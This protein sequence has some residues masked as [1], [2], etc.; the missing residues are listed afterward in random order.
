[1]IHPSVLR[2]IPEQGPFDMPDLVR[3][4]LAAGERVA[5]FPVHE[6]W[7]DIGCMEDYRMAQNETPE[8]GGGL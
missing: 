1:M 6:S 8:R 7:I 2:L 4:A 3:A 5:A